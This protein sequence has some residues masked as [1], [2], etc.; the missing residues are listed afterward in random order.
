MRSVFPPFFVAFVLSWSVAVLAETPK[1]SPYAGMESREIKALSAEDIAELRKGGGWGL[2][3]AAE[4]NGAPG[5]AHLLELQVEIGLSTDQIAAIEVIFAAMQAEAV[6]A[7][8]R[9]IETE[10]AVEAAFRSGGVAEAGLRALIGAAETARAELR[11]IHLKRHLETPPLLTPEQVARY[12]ELRG[13][14]AANP[15][16]I[17][18]KGHDPEMWKTHNG[19]D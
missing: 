2:A 9:L 8:E 16:D 18:P 10:A 19:C 1:Q 5:P 11:F 12:N 6:P 13:Y 17:V 15:C 14:V 4:L 3:L 7:G